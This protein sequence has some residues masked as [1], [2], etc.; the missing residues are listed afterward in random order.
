[1]IQDGQ[2][3]KLRKLLSCG[4][5]LASAARKTGMD[6]K[7]ARKYRKSGKL[8]SAL[9]SPRT[10]RTRIDPF[11][12][13]WP[14]VEQ[15]L[16]NEPRLRA[17]TL[18]DWLKERYPG[19]FSDSQRRTFERRVRAWRAKNGRGKEV[20]FPQIHQPGALAASDF[21]SMNSLKITIGGKRYD[22]L[23]YHLVF[24][25][26]D[27][28]AVSICM[29][30]SFE[31]FSRGFQA[32]IWKAGGVPKN[33]R[34]DSLSAAVDNLSREREFRNRYQDLMD[35]YQTTPQ[36][37]NVRKANENGDVESLHGHLKTVVDQALLL[38]GSRDFETVEAYKDFL[39]ALIDKRNLARADKF[40]QEREA[41]GELPAKKLDH[42]KHIYGIRV[43]RSSTIQVVK[44][45][46]SVPSRLIGEKVDVVIDADFIEV[47]YA[48]TLVQQ[49]PRLTGTG[50]HSINYRHVIDSLVRK[51]GAFENYQ[52]RQDMF[53][54]THFRMAYDFLCD[55]HSK[56]VA[57]REYLKI[58]QMAAHDS[59]DAV[60]EALRV[61]IAAGETISS[62]S[63][64]A[65][66]ERHQQAPPVTDIDIELPDLTEFDT[67]LQH[68]DME[69]HNHES[70]ER[71]SVPPPDRPGGPTQSSAAACPVDGAISR[72]SPSHVSGEL[73]DA[74]RS[75][76]PGESDSH[77]VSGGADGTGVPSSS[78]EPHL[79]STE[80]ITATDI[81]DVE[82]LRLEPSSSADLAT[83]RDFAGWLVLGP[84]REPAGVWETGIG[85]ESLS[86]CVGGAVGASRSVDL[87][88]DLQP[89]GTAV[90]GGQA[91]LAAS[92][93]DQAVGTIRRPDHRR[94]G[95]CSTEP[96]GDG[97]L[98]HA[99][100]G[101]VRARQRAVDQQPSVQQMGA[102]LQGRHDD[103]RGHRS[104]RASQ[105]DC[106]A[107][108]P[109]LP[110][111]EG[112]GTEKTA[113]QA[114]PQIEKPLIPEINTG[115]LIVAKAE[116]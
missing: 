9:K 5:S 47:W 100:G 62:E 63:V 43:R 95:V 113:V 67:L 34:S 115:I 22:H 26:S 13:V 39:Q 49:M 6:E 51:P 53:P 90:V 97:S 109:Q 23:L 20:F 80:S 75:S 36:R 114:C 102:D 71:E 18:F 84:C 96:G 68:S 27:W 86:L 59:Q 19:K 93:N 8:P 88:Y 76:D 40:A 57:V 44:N 25:Y 98:V 99:A 56:R 33:H 21:T 4:S 32:A 111:R 73:R 110:A 37:I 11:A 107:Q 16:E 79:A 45:T 66:I 17:F 7:T 78:G 52:Y 35:H 83:V 61:A 116:F 28:E 50:K 64:K 3:K 94:F 81:E 42:R 74:R 55:S 29:S 30:E 41:L 103:G 14:E 48:R 46:Y 104:A 87:L 54:T 60:Q 2:V 106:R 101:E 112:Q 72:T 58:L 65:A 38:R 77:S 92:Q 89:T 15:R 108:R 12:E 70:E 85:Q 31:A 1:M 10:Y 91:R 105:R 24:T 69:V 82:Q